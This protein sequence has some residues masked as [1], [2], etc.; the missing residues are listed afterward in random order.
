M[1]GKSLRMVGAESDTALVAA[2]APEIPANLFGVLDLF[3][4]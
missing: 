2:S 4:P 3:D 1:H